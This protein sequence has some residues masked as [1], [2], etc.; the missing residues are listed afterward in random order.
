MD[1]ATING[2]FFSGFSKGSRH[3]GEVNISHILVVV[4]L[5]FFGG[6]KP[7]HLPI[8]MLYFYD[9]RG[10]V[11]VWKMVPTCLCWCLWRERNNRCFE[12]LERSSEDT[13]SS[14]FHTLYLWTIA[15]VPIVD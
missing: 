1:S 11:A 12:D 3:S 8:C 7:D 10:S 5:W 14:C 9:L 13:L 4:I 2:G 15:R 6:A